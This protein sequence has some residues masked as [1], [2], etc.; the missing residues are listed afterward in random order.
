MKAHLKQLLAAGGWHLLRLGGRKPDAPRVSVAMYHT[1]GSASISGMSLD[2]GIFDAQ[3]SQLRSLFAEILTIGQLSRKAAPTD[4]T[5]CVT[6]DDGFVDNYEIALPLLKRHGIP[7][8]FFACS[9]FIDG[10]HD[11][12]S[13]FLHYRGLRPMS[14]SQVR[15]LSAEGMEIGAH[16]HSHPNLARLPPHKQR[17]E[18]HRSQCIIEDKIGAPVGSFAIPFGG[19]GTYTAETL[20]IAGRLFSACCTTHYGTNPPDGLRANGMLLLSRVQPMPRDSLDL[21]FRKMTG[22]WDAMR[23]IQRTQRTP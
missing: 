6:F 15:E 3:L 20:A 13:R 11:I 14:W 17:E 4:W 8:T 23:W 7:A 19:R 1:V 2:P 18:M 21:F 5:A 10:E 9:G 22:R 16:T 12:T